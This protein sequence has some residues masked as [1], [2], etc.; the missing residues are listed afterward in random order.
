MTIDNKKAINSQHI[1]LES[2]FPL[3]CEKEHTTTTTTTILI[4]RRS[5]N[6]D[7]WICNS[8]TWTGDRFFMEKHPC[9]QNVSNNFAK[10]AQRLQQQEFSG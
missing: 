2:F 5:P 7:T 3:L 4:R 1:G 10:V 9:R 6:S 8:C